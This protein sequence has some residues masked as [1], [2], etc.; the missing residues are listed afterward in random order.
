[1]KQKLLAGLCALLTACLLAG[2]GGDAA[3]ETSQAS[4]ASQTASQGETS[5]GETSQDTTS[6]QAE[7]SGAAVTTEDGDLI[8]QSEL[9]PV[10]NGEPVGY[11]LE[12][13]QKGEEIAVVTMATG[14]VI[15]LRF[16]PDEAPKAVYSFKTHARQGYYDGLTFH[17]IIEGFMIQGGDPNGDGTGGGERLGRALC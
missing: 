5:Q 17:R 4:G 16:F 14:E 12:L 1:M 13:P 3:S 2:C 6:S 15:K 11:Q 7:G 9:E 8:P 10:G